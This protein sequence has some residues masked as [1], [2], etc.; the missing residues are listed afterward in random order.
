MDDT[1]ARADARCRVVTKCT[2]SR[3]PNQ[4]VESADTGILPPVRNL[5]V[6][7]RARATPRWRAAEFFA[8]IGL[9]RLGLSRAGVEVI[10][11]N[12]I[13]PTKKALFDLKFGNSDSHD[14]VLKDLGSVD[15]HD[16]PADVDLA[17]ASFPCTDLSVAGG[18]AGLH[19]GIASSSFWH[20]IKALSMLSDDRPS[21]VALENVTAFATSHDGRDIE[22][23]IRALNGLGYSMDIVHID[24][25]HFV[26]QSRPRLFLIGAQIPPEVDVSNQTLRPPWL[27]KVFDNPNLVTHRMP[28]PPLPDPMTGGLCNF[29]EPIADEDP[30]WW[31]S[32]RVAAYVDSLSETQRERFDRLRR[33]RGKEFRTAYRRMRNGTPRWEMRD[34]GIAGCLRTSSGGSSKQAVVVLG[35]DAAQIRWMSPRE[36]AALMGAPE[37]PLNG[38]KDHH[39]YCGFGDAVCAPAVTWLAEN[40]LVPLLEFSLQAPSSELVS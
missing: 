28:L 32:V 3:C 9:A 7:R 31:D 21:V 40:Y 12:D 20:F 10:W 34:D 6:E 22:S 4:P 24:A 2:E 17:W 29:L 15:R 37:F 27:D 13:A 25:V 11:S 14:F 38:V 39:A 35:D 8:G 36:Y 23:A 1:N 19:R 26:P 16:L 30:R 5:E 18:R 33:K